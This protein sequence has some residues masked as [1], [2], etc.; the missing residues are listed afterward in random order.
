MKYINQYFEIIKDNRVLQIAPD[1]SRS[2]SFHCGSKNELR[3]H[4][5]TLSEPGKDSLMVDIEFWRGGLPMHIDI[6][7]NNSILL[8][9]CPIVLQDRVIFSEVDENQHRYYDVSCELSRYDTLTFGTE[10]LR[11][12]FINRFNPHHTPEMTVPFIDRVKVFIQ[13]IRNQLKCPPLS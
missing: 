2:S 4:H 13:T 7:S 5:R 12:T 9:R 8:E 3:K 11:A 10:Q 1:R 6:F